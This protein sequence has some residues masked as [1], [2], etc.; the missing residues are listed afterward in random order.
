MEFK[1]LET[2]RWI[3]MLFTSL[4]LDKQ[5][6]STR[7]FTKWTLVCRWLKPSLETIT[8]S[9]IYFSISFRP[10]NQWSLSVLFQRPT[11]LETWLQV[12][13]IWPYPRLSKSELQELRLKSR[14]LR[15][16]SRWWFQCWPKSENFYNRT[17]SKM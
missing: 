10:P 14:V 17:T 8:V 3:S 9:Q 13:F 1:Y 11:S 2:N 6:P 7:W 4:S 15:C 5:S 12:Q 16:T